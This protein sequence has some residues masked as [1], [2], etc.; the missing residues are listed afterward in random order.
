MFGME[1]SHSWTADLVAYTLSNAIE[2]VY[3]AFF[4]TASAHTLWQQPEEILLSLFMTTLNAA[5]EWKLAL[6]DEGY[7]SSSEIFNIPTPLRRTSKIHHIS[8][9]ENA[10][11]DPDPVTSCSTGQ[12]HLRPVCRQLTYSSSNHVDSSEDEALSPSTNLWTTPHRPDPQS[13][14]SRSTLDVKVYLEENKEEDFQTVPLDD[15]HWTTEEV[16]NRTLCIHEHSLPQ[17]LCPYPLPYAN[18]LLPSYIE[19]MDLS[20]I[21]DFENIMIMSSDEDIPALEDTPYWKNTGL[22]WVFYIDYELF[23]LYLLFDKLLS[24][25]ICM[26]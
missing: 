8:S 6:E 12:S 22:H 9:V 3:S 7:K 23:N 25:E 13:S 15:E 4:Y 19:T 24:L 17:G 1:C 14:T 18:Y 5:F 26:Y 11:F 16:S 21:L 2:E 20:D 10:S